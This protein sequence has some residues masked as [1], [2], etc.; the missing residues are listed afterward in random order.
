LAVTV[1]IRLRSI[2]LT[3]VPRGPLK[4][5]LF[6]KYI[7]DRLDAEIHSIF[8]GRRG[9]EWLAFGNRREC[10]NMTSAPLKERYVKKFVLLHYG[11]ETPTPEIMDAW[12]KWFESIAEVTVD[13][14]GFSAGREISDKGTTDLPWGKDTITGYNVIEAESLDAAEKVAIACPFISGIRV[15]EIREM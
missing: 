12:G 5:H 3:K 14:G 2:E 4:A 10:P 6:S 13:Q 8:P 15:Y 9:A 11:F 7:D 1:L